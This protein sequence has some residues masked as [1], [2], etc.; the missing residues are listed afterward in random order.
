MLN[1][2][3]LLLLLCFH[4]RVGNIGVSNNVKCHK[5]T[6]KRAKTGKL[7][8]NAKAKQHKD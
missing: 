8:Q 3:S 5:E 4:E 2:S 1:C 7:N 6:K